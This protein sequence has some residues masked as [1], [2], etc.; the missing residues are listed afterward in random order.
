MTDY[1][2]HFDT[3]STRQDLRPRAEVAPVTKPITRGDLPDGIAVWPQERLPQD[4]PPDIL[5]G[6]YATFHPD[7]TLHEVGAVKS[8]H[9]TRTLRLEP[10]A[11]GG[12]DSGRSAAWATYRAD[13]TIETGSH[14]DDDSPPR[15]A[16]VGFRAWALG[17]VQEMVKDHPTLPVAVRY[18]PAW[19]LMEPEWEYGP[20][21]AGADPCLQVK[22]GPLGRY[23]PWFCA[24]LLDLPAGQVADAVAAA[25]EGTWTAP[26]EWQGPEAE[27]VLESAGR[28]LRVL[29]RRQEGV[30]LLLGALPEGDYAPTREAMRAM[31]AGARW[32]P[33][34]VPPA[35]PRRRAP[36]PL[37]TPRWA[38]SR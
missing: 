13:G 17:A 34:A 12:T 4:L 18:R 6:V 33:L 9:Y 32:N 1:I 23:H 19:E 3:A 8:R 16:R 27:G 10:G 14:W 24:Y 29:V 22:G 5:D 15:P 11:A 31:M 21:V 28:P 38:R 35:G 2:K 25:L 20:T 26:L 7:G 36:W 37:W 30:G